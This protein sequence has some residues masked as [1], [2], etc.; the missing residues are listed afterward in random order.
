MRKRIKERWNL[1]KTEV[2]VT[3]VRLCTEGTACLSRADRISIIAGISAL[4]IFT[5]TGQVF[6]GGGDIISTGG[7]V[8][9]DLYDSLKGIATKVAGFGLAACIIWFFLCTNEEDAKRPLRWGKRIVIAYV[10]FRL[11]FPLLN[12]I[13]NKTNGF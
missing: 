6:A 13:D 1:L 7:D 2:G 5:M 10:I 3:Y 4:F 8:A 11:I 9:S 12:F